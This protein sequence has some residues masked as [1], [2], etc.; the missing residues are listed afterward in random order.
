MIRDVIVSELVSHYFGQIQ[1]FACWLMNK[2]KDKYQ[3]WR[4]RIFVSQ[5]HLISEGKG[6]FS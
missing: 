1:D 5:Y 2:R 4:Q 3:A 6:I